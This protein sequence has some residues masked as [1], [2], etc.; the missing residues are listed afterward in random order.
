M[1]Q[2]TPNPLF[3]EGARTPLFAVLAGDWSGYAARWSASAAP[4]AADP[5]AFF[6]EVFEGGKLW[7]TRTL[8][9]RRMSLA[10]AEDAGRAAARRHL[11]PSAPG[12]A[13]AYDAFAARVL[14]PQNPESPNTKRKRLLYSLIDASLLP[15]RE[16]VGFLDGL[17]NSD[18]LRAAAEF[19]S[20][21]QPAILGSFQK[22]VEALLA[23]RPDG[24]VAAVLLTG[25]YAHGSAKES[26][27]FDVL[28]LTRDGTGRGAPEFMA[29][30]G[31]RRAADGWPAWKDWERYPTN[32]ILGV[33]DPETLPFV[34]S[35]PM[36]VISP[37]AVLRARLSA[38]AGTRP[39]WSPSLVDSWLE[40][41]TRSARAW[42]V[43]RELARLP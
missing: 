26:S 6:A 2:N 25:S 3:G 7:W 19:R 39:L 11:E 36:I 29:E 40:R 15:A 5:R 10:A 17:L 35:L 18:E 24:N 42:L 37:D 14:A 38:Q 12:A 43:R 1:A 22:E 32:N 34:R 31:A 4:A 23:A 28:V 20:A 27:D 41:L 8:W 16:V 30:L 33:D 9:G 21:R 13:A